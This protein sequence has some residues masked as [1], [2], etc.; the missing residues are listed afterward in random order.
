MKQYIVA[1]NWK[2]HKDIPESRIF[3]SNILDK[4]IKQQRSTIILCPPFT[5]L[6]NVYEL[7]RNT[8]IALGGQNMHS[9]P[10]GAFTGEISGEMLLSAGCQYVILGHSERR[11]IFGETDDF[12]RDKVKRA[13]QVGLKPIICV[14][15]KLNERQS[16][17]T[18]DVVRRQCDSALSVV[19]EQEIGHCVIA[20]EPV[21]AIGTGVVATPQQASEAHSMIRKLLSAKYGAENAE[22]IPILYGGSVKS[23]NA[24]SLIQAQDIDGFL[25]GGASLIE[26]EFVRIAEIVED[27]VKQREL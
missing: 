5:A 20:Y 1:G 2:M 3:V 16:G 23:S 12:I 22:V 18:L 24:A 6:F 15:E 7:I 14:G 19:N 11:H 13:L 17:E 10:K 25:I 21:W 26:D 9:E 8:S 27:Y 4:L